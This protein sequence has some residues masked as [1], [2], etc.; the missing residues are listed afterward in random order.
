MEQNTP[1]P[2][3]HLRA[4]KMHLLIETW[5]QEKAPNQ[6]QGIVCLFPT[7]FLFFPHLA[8]PLGFVLNGAEKSMPLL[9]SNNN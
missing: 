3:K 5:V 9:F 8:N 2:W 4:W 6:I 7:Y 1:A